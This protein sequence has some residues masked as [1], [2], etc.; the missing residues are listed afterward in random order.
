MNE[1][2]FF[3]WSINN[4]TSDEIVKSN[5]NQGRTLISYKWLDAICIDM[6]NN[7]WN[8]YEIGK[9]QPWAIINYINNNDEYRFPTTDELRRLFSFKN[10]PEFQEY[11]PEIANLETEYYFVSWALKSLFSMNT[12]IPDVVTI[13]GNDGFSGYIRLDGRAFNENWE[14]ILENTNGWARWKV[15][16]ILIKK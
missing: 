2:N 10:E 16:F 7:P 14:Y 6:I 3:Q 5:D 13:V 11:F 4:A 15:K 1:S 9:F 8:S 12:N